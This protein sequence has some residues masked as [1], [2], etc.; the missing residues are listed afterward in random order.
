MDRYGA[1]K[2]S[3]VER[4]HVPECNGRPTVSLDDGTHGCEGSTR[5]DKI[6]AVATN[7]PRTA[8]L[9]DRAIGIL[10]ANCIKLSI[11]CCTLESK[12]RLLENIIG[13]CNFVV[14]STLS[15]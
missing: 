6:H 2:C 8:Y 13:T 4:L 11:L 7:F 5:P 14:L 10:Y 9:Y 12:R 15:L 1:P 3:P